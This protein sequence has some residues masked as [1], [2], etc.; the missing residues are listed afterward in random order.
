MGDGILQGTLGVGKRLGRRAEGHGFADVVA[1]LS[2][3][4]ALV[5]RQT[6]LEGDIVAW[7]EVSDFS[8]DGGDGTGGFVAEGERLA[9]LDVA[10]AEV[11]EVVQVGA[12]EAC[13]ADLDED[14]GGGELGESAFFLGRV[15]GHRGLLRRGFE[16]AGEC[17]FTYNPEIFCAVEH[18]GSYCL[19]SHFV[20]CKELNETSEL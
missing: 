1:A 8:A 15:L 13:G 20:C 4:G 10:V 11:G 17:E 16:C 7:G 2:A 5:A 18:R 14:V 19:S 3:E 9:D 12:A 6:D